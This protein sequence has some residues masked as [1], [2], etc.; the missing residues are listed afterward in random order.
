MMI[1]GCI[2][3]ISIYYFLNHFL[4]KKQTLLILILLTI[5]P[6]FQFF[7]FLTV[8]DPINLIILFFSLHL[9]IK[10]LKNKNSKLLYLTGVLA[11]IGICIKY[12][13]IIFYLPLF[14][15]ILY[16]YKKFSHEEKLANS[17][18]IL[19]NFIL[20][21]VFFWLSVRYL[22]S[23]AIA[24]P[25]TGLMILI[26]IYLYIQSSIIHH[27]IANLIQKIGTKKIYYILISIITLSIC[28]IF[29]IPQFTRMGNNFLTDQYLI[30]NKQVYTTIITKNISLVSR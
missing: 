25:L 15:S 22:P 17:L 24:L 27:K 5:N 29:F 12:H 2:L 13:A 11:G 8:L 6:I 14:I 23:Q 1:I 10:G 28:S 26:Q 20:Q 7:T 18:L 3:L 30:F 16:F 9:L 19:P 4:E 21:T